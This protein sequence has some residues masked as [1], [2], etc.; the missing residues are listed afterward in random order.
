MNHATLDLSV[1]PH[2]IRIE[3]R[4]LFGDPNLRFGILDGASLVKPEV[5]TL[6]S[7]ADAVVVAVGFDPTNEAE[8]SDR[9]FSLPPA[10]DALIAAALSA[11]KKTVVVITSGGAVDM[12]SWIDQTPAVLQAWYAGQES[13]TALAESCLVRPIRQAN[14]P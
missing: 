7:R 5:K 9:T 6:A 11:N 14:S 1:G 13:G 8:G 12:N 10:Q 2:K 3:L 4:R